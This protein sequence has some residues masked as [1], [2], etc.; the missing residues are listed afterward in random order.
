MRRWDPWSGWHTG[1][2]APP[3]VNEGNNAHSAHGVSGQVFILCP[4]ASSGLLLT[5]YVLCREKKDTQ[6]L[7]HCFTLP[8]SCWCFFL[9]HVVAGVCADLC[10][11]FMGTVSSA[12]SRRKV[13]AV[14]KEE[15]E[16]TE[17]E[18]TEQRRALNTHTGHRQGQT[19]TQTRISTTEQEQEQEQ[20]KWTQT[21]LE[22][23]RGGE[24]Q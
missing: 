5:L 17:Q 14:Q 16:D 23:G 2:T 18:D 20:G 24:G 4:E 19:I 21:H 9:S 11:L 8:A 7:S 13:A 15:Q 1:H 10:V 3:V 22:R 6:V 12:L